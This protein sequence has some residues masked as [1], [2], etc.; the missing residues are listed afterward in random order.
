MSHKF[1]R[2]IN[3]ILSSEYSFFVYF[4]P[5]LRNSSVLSCYWCLVQFN[6][7]T[8][9]ELLDFSKKMIRDRHMQNVCDKITSFA[10][11]SK[12][13]GRNGMF[14]NFYLLPSLYFVCTL[15]SWLRFLWL[16]EEG[17]DCGKRLMTLAC[18][19]GEVHDQ[20]LCPFGVTGYWLSLFSL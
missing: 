8:E 9:G 12:I 13:T 20:F 16:K 4:F 1:W 14:S 6:A 2:M 5:N 11:Y 7:R 18:K 3:K 10:E 19:R 15:A 17:V